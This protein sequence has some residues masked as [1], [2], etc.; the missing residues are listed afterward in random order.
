MQKISYS[1]ITALFSAL[2]AFK[3]EFTVEQMGI[4]CGVIR[5]TI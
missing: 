2:Q 5:V 4:T 3:G 1:S